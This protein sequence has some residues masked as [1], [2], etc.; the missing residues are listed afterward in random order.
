MLHRQ[1]TGADGGTGRG[2]WAARAV[3]SCAERGH[4]LIAVGR[5][6]P[7]PAGDHAEALGLKA[8]KAA[9]Y[10]EAAG[11]ACCPLREGIAVE[12]LERL[13]PPCG[14]LKSSAQAGP[15]GGGFGHPQG[16]WRTAGVAGTAPFDGVEP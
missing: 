13:C 3:L 15:S 10:A 6:I 1:P 14:A 12:A 7:M 9:S 2:R 5:Q 4:P 16:P 11:C 8:L